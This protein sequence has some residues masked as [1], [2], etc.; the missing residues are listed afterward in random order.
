MD[1]RHALQLVAV[2]EEEEV[3]NNTAVADSQRYFSALNKLFVEKLSIEESGVVC[4]LNN[5]GNT[6]YFAS[7]I[8]A[9][10]ACPQ[11]LSLLRLVTPTMTASV[12]GKPLVNGLPFS[13]SSDAQYGAI[14]YVLPPFPIGQFLQSVEGE[15]AAAL[16]GLGGG[17][18][19]TGPKLAD[20][21]AAKPLKAIHVI[22]D[23]HSWVNWATK[24]LFSSSSSAD[25]TSSPDTKHFP[26]WAEFQSL[27]Q[28]MRHAGDAPSTTPVVLLRTLSTAHPQFEGLQQQD[29]G[30][31]VHQLLSSINDA[32][33]VAARSED[34]WQAVTT[35]DVPSQLGD[36]GSF[37]GE[38]VFALPHIPPSPIERYPS[39]PG[40]EGTDSLDASSPMSLA[41]LRSLQVLA[42]LNRINLENLVRE[43]AEAERKQHGGK[44]LKVPGGEGGASKARLLQRFV[45]AGQGRYSPP[46]LFN[47]ALTDPFTGFTLSAITCGSCGSCSRT[48]QAFNT[49]PLA[50]PKP[51]T[52]ARF[53]ALH[54]EYV[55]MR[56]NARDHEARTAQKAAE[57]RFAGTAKALGRTAAEVA[58]E[59]SG[60]GSHHDASTLNWVDILQSAAP[61]STLTRAVVT[62][63]EVSRFVINTPPVSWAIGRAMAFP[64]RFHKRLPTGL[65]RALSQ[66]GRIPTRAFWWLFVGDE[67]VAY[68][69]YINASTGKPYNLDEVDYP[70]T[71]DECLRIHFGLP[72]TLRGEN[73]YRCE[74]CGVKGESSKVTRLL[75]APKYLV[76][77]L[78]R[79]G[80]SG[81]LFGRKDATDV[82]FPMGRVATGDNHDPA[83][84][85]GYLEMPLDLVP[86]F[87]TGCEGG[88]AVRIQ[89]GDAGEGMEEFLPQDATPL[90]P[91]LRAEYALNA[92][93]NHHGATID[94]GHYTSCSK[95]R[96][97]HPGRSSTRTPLEAML[98]AESTMGSETWVNFNDERFSIVSPSNVMDT[99]GYM[100]VYEREESRPLGSLAMEMCLSEDGLGTPEYH[101][102]KQLDRCYNGDT[103]KR[104]REFYG[105]GCVGVDGDEADLRGFLKERILQSTAAE[106]R[107]QV[108]A[109][110]MLLDPRLVGDVSVCNEAE[111]FSR[112]WLATAA[113]TL[114]PGP[115][116]T[117]PTTTATPAAGAAPSP[118]GSGGGGSSLIQDPSIRKVW[119]LS[120]TS[121]PVASFA[122]FA[123][124]VFTSVYNG[125]L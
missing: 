95:R 114:E 37:L 90:M 100:L 42:M 83:A 19:L 60:R 103:I 72:E 45:T 94:G 116:I 112:G 125:A 32:T 81:G 57:S 68:T 36:V 40:E 110:A 5:I 2:T 14:P 31:M 46:K 28:Q 104:I 89:R 96:V 43:G 118:H 123:K 107:A 17:G 105:I 18:R 124:E 101:H 119:Y 92:V 15:G 97:L 1:L 41:S 65:Q 54:P 4:G 77:Q 10:L 34:L 67:E 84:Q 49:L 33:R 25:S 108:L 120:G 30:E 71:L 82:T 27:V 109:R 80:G 47:S 88:Y 115:F 99:E 51:I 52:R 3:S 74:V 69:D 16:G 50:I 86:F 62:S 12:E 20:L 122:R 48:Y 11:L 9:L 87:S 78:L 6:C 26:V 91:P 22:G 59:S 8:Q 58:A 39:T 79:F 7:G 85:R 76:I 38:R 121:S 35:N 111:L 102:L 44:P 24:G 63:V 93:I 66:L 56:R 75:T 61:D 98:S 23:A 29:S 70:L 13:T 64:T 106:A 55:A 73:T 113:T 53:A 21:K 117:H